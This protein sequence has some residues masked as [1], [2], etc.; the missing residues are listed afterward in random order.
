MN[1]PLIRPLR[2]Y[3]PFWLGVT[4]VAVL[5]VLVVA[6]VGLGELGIGQAGYRA[7]FTQ[8]GELRPGD[9]ARVA[10]LRVGEVTVIGLEGD[11]VLVSFRVARGVHLGRDTAASIKLAS[12]LGRRYL[13]LRPAGPGELPDHRIPLAHTSVPYDLQ[14]VLQTGT[15]LAEQ[16]DPA[17][18]SRAA[19]GV[20]DTFRGD[21][22]KIG[23]A[24]AGLSRLSGVISKRREQIAHLI[25]SADA[26]TTLVNQ[27]SDRLFALL[28]Q[29]DT[30]LRELLRRRDVIRGVLTDLARFTGQ[31]RAALAENQSRIRP[32]LDNTAQLTDVLRQQDVAVDQALQLIA[33]AGRYLDNTLGNGPYLEI[34]LPY[35]IVP[36]NVLCRAHAASGCRR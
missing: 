29:S 26:V 8:A 32:L 34:Y 1:R 3:S 10:G 6:T 31:L 12:L 16:L 35:S 15:P 28:G 27:R 4:V 23:S 17:A 13:E 30:L 19:R 5:A 11:H 18:L 22:E 25:T 7:E 36:D 21:R 2:E 33:P 9:D 20:A 24:L 14:K